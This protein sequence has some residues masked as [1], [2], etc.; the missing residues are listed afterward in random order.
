MLS[1][2]KSHHISMKII[3][4]LFTV[5][6]MIVGYQVS[7]AREY[8]R[9]IDSRV[10]LPDN[11]VTNIVQ[12]TKGYIW[13]GTSNGLSRY[14]GVTFTTFRHD[15]DDNTS[16]SSSTVNTLA[17]S[18]A[19]IFAG[20]NSGLDLYSFAYGGFI[21][22]SIKPKSVIRISLCRKAARNPLFCPK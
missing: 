11:T 12:D 2:S 7:T 22:C 5:I 17:V 18:Q 8:F 3:K 13:L 1:P 16:L 14:D 10:G 15:P 6:C 4:L 9:V 21:H 20:T 19:G